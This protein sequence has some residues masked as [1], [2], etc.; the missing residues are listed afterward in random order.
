MRG[1]TTCGH[2]KTFS[3]VIV[4]TDGSSKAHCFANGNIADTATENNEITTTISQITISQKQRTRE[5]S[6]SSST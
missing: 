2:V 1:L 5:P 6:N 4:S 3:P